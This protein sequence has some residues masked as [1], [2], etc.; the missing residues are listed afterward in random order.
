MFTHELLD[1]QPWESSLW[2]R[3]DRE[4]TT[5]LSWGKKA[6]TRLYSHGGR[7]STSIT[8]ASSSLQVHNAPPSLCLSRGLGRDLYKSD[9]VN[10][11]SLP[12]GLG[13]LA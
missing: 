12:V 2:V 4:M 3:Q 13:A 10:D 1:F 5:E 9:S 8:S 7:P 11:G 6:Y